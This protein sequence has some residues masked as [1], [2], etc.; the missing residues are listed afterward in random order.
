[1]IL[2]LPPASTML[3]VLMPILDTVPR[4]PSTST[5]SLT[6]Y[7]FSMIMNKPVMTSA[8]SDSAP[9]PITRAT[10]PRDA[11]IVET[12]TPRRFKPKQMAKMTAA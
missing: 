8:I 9:K 3:V 1:M 6:L 7:W 12:S 5:M 11:T 4:K 10:I 2:T